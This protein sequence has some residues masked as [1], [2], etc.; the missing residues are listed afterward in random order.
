MPAREGMGGDGPYESTAAVERE[1]CWYLRILFLI[2]S[3]PNTRRSRKRGVALILFA[4]LGRCR[5]TLAGFV[6][7]ESLRGNL[8]LPRCRA[9]RGKLQELR[10]WPGSL[11]AA[12]WDSPTNYATHH[13]LLPPS[14]S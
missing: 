6:A 11:W 3:H 14:S 8:H 7:D 4:L 5:T 2:C 1:R 9:R 13:P 10:L 12:L